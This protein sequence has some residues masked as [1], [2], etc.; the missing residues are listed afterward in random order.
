MKTL[1]NEYTISA[2]YLVKGFLKDKSIKDITLAKWQ[3]FMIKLF[4]KKQYAIDNG[5][6]L[7]Y[8][9]YKGKYYVLTKIK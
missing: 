7:Q 8:Y 2:T 5:E 9:V 6:L 1:D 4:G 3:R